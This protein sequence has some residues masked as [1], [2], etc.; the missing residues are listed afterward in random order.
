MGH[1][2]LVISW[3]FIHDTAYANS[4]EIWKYP[5]RKRKKGE[6]R[7]KVYV[8]IWFV[9]SSSKRAVNMLGLL[10]GPSFYICAALSLT[11]PWHIIPLHATVARWCCWRWYGCFKQ[12]ELAPV[13]VAVSDALPSREGDYIGS[14]TTP[15]LYLHLE[16]DLK[17]LDLSLKVE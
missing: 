14:G 3:S 6:G 12:D 17:S 8:V 10:S 5:F 4:D 16:I 1:W 15:T 11:V 13:F 2:S 7:L 9:H